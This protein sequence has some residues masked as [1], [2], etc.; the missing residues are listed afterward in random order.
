MCK[1]CCRYIAQNLPHLFTSSSLSKISSVRDMRAGLFC[2]MRHCRG[3]SLVLEASVLV[4]SPSQVKPQIQMLHII[5]L[6]FV[7]WSFQYLGPYTIEWG[8]LMNEELERKCS[9]HIRGTMTAFACL[10]GVRK[11]VKT[12]IYDNRRSCRDSNRAPP[13]YDCRPLLSRHCVLCTPL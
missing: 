5:L 6:W 11:T 3:G 12:L 1:I 4:V 7:L 2:C 10:G 8:W 9:W 13:E